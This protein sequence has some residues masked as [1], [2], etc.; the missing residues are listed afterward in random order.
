MSTHEEFDRFHRAR[1]MAESLAEMFDLDGDMMRFFERAVLAA[2]E[3]G[4]TNVVVQVQCAA[5]PRGI[6]ATMHGGASITITYTPA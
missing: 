4:A 3:W 2:L 6:V 1:M 5:A